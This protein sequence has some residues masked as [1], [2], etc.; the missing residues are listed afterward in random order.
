MRIEFPNEE[1][2]P[3]LKGLWQEAFGDGETFI[4]L[5]FKT[6]YAP[7]RCRCV[8]E[9]EQV[10]AAAY[11]MDA[12][13]RG[14]R[15]AYL[16]AVATASDFRG[17]GLCR[18]LM[19]DIREIL[20]LR[21]YDAVLLSPAGEDLKKMYE[22]MGYRPFSRKQEISA[23]AGTEVPLREIGPEEYACLRRQYLPENGVI[24]EGACLEFLAGYSRFYAGEDFLTAVSNDE[25]ILRA[26]ELLGRREAAPGIVAALGCAC[27]IFRLRAEGMVLL[28]EQDAP[29]PGWMGLVFD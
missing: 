24:Q 19:E 11:W 23:A 20:A 21:G 4:D 27:G 10:A 26:Q 29:V 12:E 17:R 1:I 16:Y 5:F 6:A 28:L 9:G 7:D 13:Y 3:G 15:F 8:L 14:R 18:R 25:K 2:L 22:K